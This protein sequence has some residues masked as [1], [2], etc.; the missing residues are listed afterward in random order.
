MALEPNDIRDYLHDQVTFPADT[1]SVLA[2]IGDIEIAAPDT[3]ESE[4]VES[5]L[6]GVDAETYESADELNQLLHSMLPD[7]Y[8][9]R[10]YYDDRSDEPQDRSVRQDEEDQSF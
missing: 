2:E 1:E 4:T 6:A 9:G 7:E 8:V 5:L 3:E 10:K